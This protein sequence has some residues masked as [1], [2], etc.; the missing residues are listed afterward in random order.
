MKAKKEFMNL[1]QFAVEQAKKKGADA[2]EAFI[3]D[4]QE[5]QINVSSRWLKQ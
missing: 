1:A 5:V 4:T 3:S 2:A